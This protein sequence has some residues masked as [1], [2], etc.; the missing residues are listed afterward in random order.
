[1]DNKSVV[2]GFKIFNNDLS[3]RYGMKF[4]L[5]KIYEING[6]IEWGIKGN[7]FHFCSYLEDTFRYYDAMNTKVQVAIVKGFGEIKEFSDEYYGYYDMHVC[8][9]IIIQRLLEH[10]E[11][12]NYLYKLLDSNN[13]NRVLRFISG[14]KLSKAEIKNV[15]LLA[16][17][18]DFYNIDLYE[19]A[20]KRYQKIKL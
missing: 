1:M 18:N 16:K 5:N 2:Y 12:I 20:I 3:N 15:L 8:S 14:Y 13:R 19:Q 10:S 11:I 7:G 9:K 4:E 17:T 6:K